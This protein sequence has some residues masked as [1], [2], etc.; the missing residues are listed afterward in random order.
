MPAGIELRLNCDKLKYMLSKEM[1]TQVCLS[2]QEK[3]VVSEICGG[4]VA[5]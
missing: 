1:N 2:I 5:C 4:E 3:A